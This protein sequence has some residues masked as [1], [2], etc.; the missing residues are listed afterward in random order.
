MMITQWNDLNIEETDGEPEDEP[1][2]AKYEHP[3]TKNKIDHNLQKG[4]KIVLQKGVKVM[5]VATQNQKKT[6][7]VRKGKTK[8]VGFSAVT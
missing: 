7:A 5:N 8:T 3:N 1:T 6:S 2:M 4:R